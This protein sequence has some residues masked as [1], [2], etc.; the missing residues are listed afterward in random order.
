M[1]APALRTACLLTV[2]AL[3]AAAP[4][5]Q[6]PRAPWRT[7]QTSHYRIHFPPPLASWAEEVAGRIEGIHAQVVAEVGYESPKPVQVILVDPMQEANGMAVALLPYPYVTLWRTPAQS[8]NLHGGAMT[9]W[10]DL[11][12]THE[13]THIH[14]LLRPSRQPGLLSTWFGLPIGPLLLKAPR[15]VS[16][17]YATLVEGRITGSGRPHSAVRA[18]ILRQWARAGKLPAY[19]RL[20]GTQGFQGGNMAYM[21]GSAYL[22]W[23]ERQR[24][25]QP[26][27]LRRFWKQLASKNNRNFEAAFKATFGF[28]AEEG[29]QRFQAE[30]AH[31]ALE[32]ELRFKA[33]GLREGELWFRSEGGGITD[34]A[35]SPNGTQLLARLER[36]KG[37]G[38][39][40]WDLKP[41]PAKP[42]KPGPV[43]PLN[44]V[45]DAP[46]E[47]VPPV[48]RYALAALD[49]RQPLQAEWVDDQTIR[50]QLK[51]ADDEGTLTRRPALWRLGVGV[52][53]DPMNPPAP[54]W[55]T[56]Q[57]V[58]RDGRWQL[59]MDGR[60]VPLPGQPAGQAVVDESRRQIL[61]ACDLD[62]VWNLVR[63]PFQRTAGQL[64]FQPAQ[65]LTRTP[66]AAWNPA[67]SP[68]GRWLFYT[69]LD[70]RGIEIR[71]LDLNLPPLTSPAAPEPRLLTQAT[72]MPAAPEPGKL[73]AAVPAAPSQPYRAADNLWNQMTS[74]ARLGPSGSSYQ[75]GGGGADLLGRLSWAVLAG[76]GDGAGPR[77]AVL[78]VSSTGWL[79]KP[80][81]T[82]F[83]ALERPSRQALLPVQADRERRGAEL[84]LAYDNRGETPFW[85]SPALAWERL[86][87]LAGDRGGPVASR[88]SLSLNTGLQALWARGAW[89]LGLRPALALQQGSSR[90]EGE[91]SS[92]T[93]Q[94]LSLALRFET[95]ILPLTLR[96]EQGRLSGAA[97]ERFHLGGTASSLVPASLDLDRIE[98]PALPSFS[99]AGNRFQSWRGELGGVLHAYLEGTALWDDGLPRGRFQRVAGLEFTL[100]N[101]GSGAAEGVLKKLKI[102][103]G[104]HRPLD[105]VMKGRTVGT[106]DLLVRP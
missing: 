101:G 36:A 35:V 66:A 15:W 71:R 31:D 43:D 94:R 33:E 83:S 6:A 29:Y 58:H 97:Q 106:L 54:S 10:T 98:Q 80:A 68:D 3:L 46:A 87:P 78:G 89:G 99:A 64:E 103:L 53:R 62:G 32:W 14:H 11:L 5:R 8:D 18:G 102:Q 82:A 88:T 4:G 19:A 55:R 30:T 34:L 59:E 40:V 25:E 73:P 65:R 1:F 60:V 90:T 2:P 38:L 9:S 49:H 12:V 47:F 85:V 77:G 20:S 63:V 56:L 23:L 96:A 26:D 67:P 52:Q 69:S 51:R 104:V 86:Q 42:A 70:A 39:R 45:E 13:L 74:A 57:P 37:A 48:Q 50:F 24:P 79:W 93:S 84:A 92:W 21:V 91:A 22:E 105:G 44:A 75:I 17:G 27:I 76:F 72:V 81:L 16:E 28:P 41:K 100:E 95:P 7:I 61:A